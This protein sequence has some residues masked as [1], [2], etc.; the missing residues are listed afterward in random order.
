MLLVVSYY[1]FTGLLKGLL[2]ADVA[3]EIEHPLPKI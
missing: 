3:E 2:L 1:L